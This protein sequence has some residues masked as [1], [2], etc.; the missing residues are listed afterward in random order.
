MELRS[1]VSHIYRD[2]L[3]KHL[4]SVL[5]TSGLGKLS[6]ALIEKVSATKDHHMTMPEVCVLCFFMLIKAALLCSMLV[7]L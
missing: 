2:I 6:A 3:E 7:R 1:E 4:I 5:L